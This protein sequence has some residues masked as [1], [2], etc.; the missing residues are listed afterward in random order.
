MFKDPQYSFLNSCEFWYSRSF[1]F[2]S[3]T[4][5]FS[6]HLQAWCRSLQKRHHTDPLRLENCGRNIAS[7]SQWRSAFCWTLGL[8]EFSI[9]W[10]M[11]QEPCSCVRVCGCLTACHIPVV[12]LYWC[13]GLWVPLFHD[14]VQPRVA[15][16]CH[17]SLG[18]WSVHDL[19]C[20][21]EPNP[22]E[23]CV[24]LQQQVV[25]QTDCC[26]HPGVGGEPQEPIRGPIRSTLGCR[27]Q[28]VGAWGGHRNGPQRSHRPVSLV[29][30]DFNDCDSSGMFHSLSP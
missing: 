3:G 16:M 12:R 26:P 22:L 28:F 14:N 19:D 2:T 30:S 25:Q 21:S 10:G 13:S 24:W 6:I 15:G 29:F 7:F 1:I 4:I 20:S 11:W 18:G 8:I 9:V 5:S 27:Q 23:L 17:P